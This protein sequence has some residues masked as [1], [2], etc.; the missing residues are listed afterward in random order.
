MASMNIVSVPGSYA[1]CRLAPEASLPSWILDCEPK[2]FLSITRTEDELS[3]LCLEKRVPEGTVVEKTWA[4]LKVQG[5]LDFAL[6]GILS[7]LAQPLAVA[8]ISIF[9]VSTYDTDY[10]LVKT[11]ALEGA[12]K[13]LTD[14][15]NKVE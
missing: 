13:V 1:V 6:T 9:A 4:V 7:A 10:L 3:I 12:K 15:G 14:A 5:P 2:E 11:E 8:G